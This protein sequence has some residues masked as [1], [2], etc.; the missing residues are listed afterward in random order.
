MNICSPSE[1]KNLYCLRHILMLYRFCT[2]C[3]VDW[4][5]VE[6]YSNCGEFNWNWDVKGETLPRK[7]YYGI[8]FCCL[9]RRDHFSFLR[10]LIIS[11]LPLVLLKFSFGVSTFGISERYPRFA[12]KVLLQLM[13]RRH[14]STERCIFR[15]RALMFP[16][17]PGHERPLP[18]PRCS[19]ADEIG[20]TC[21]GINEDENH[22]RKYN[23]RG[24]T[25]NVLIS[26][27][28][29]FGSEQQKQKRTYKSKS[30]DKCLNLI[31]RVERT[32]QH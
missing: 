11:S 9:L 6:N 13:K 16:C 28:F 30:K 18:A 27:V 10:P 2:N 21:R 12:L 31:P 24:R 1:L 4:T 17:T 5:C 23:K 26:S 14:M 22:E 25:G 32:V 20:R 19:R 7:N 29:Q 15:K 8:Y 3:F